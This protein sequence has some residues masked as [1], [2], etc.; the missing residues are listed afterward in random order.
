MRSSARCMVATPQLALAY[1]LH[2][3][4]KAQATSS[5]DCGLAHYSQLRGEVG[6]HGPC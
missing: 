5:P 2:Y 1:H 3:V 4:G 6:R